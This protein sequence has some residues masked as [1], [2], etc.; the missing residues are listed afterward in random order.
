VVIF[1]QDFLEKDGRRSL[2]LAG[3]VGNTSNRLPHYCVR[4]EV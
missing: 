2:A 1:Y 3:D 4:S